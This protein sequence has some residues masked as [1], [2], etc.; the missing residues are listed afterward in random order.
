MVYYPNCCQFKVHFFI[1]RSVCVE[2]R[3]LIVIFFG[4]VSLAEDRCSSQSRAYQREQAEQPLLSLRRD[5]DRGSA[6]YRW[7]HHHADI[8]WTTV[9]LRGEKTDPHFKKHTHPPSFLCWQGAI[10]GWS[11]CL[12]SFREIAGS[13]STRRGFDCRLNVFDVWWMMTGLRLILS[14]PTYLPGPT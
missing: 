2:I 9:W 5:R 6:S 4:R 10:S 7:W 11:R 8:R 12:K 13:F 1:S 3:L 14:M